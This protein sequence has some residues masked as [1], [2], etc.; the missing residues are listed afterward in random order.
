MNNLTNSQSAPRDLNS[1]AKKYAQ[2]IYG[3]VHPQDITILMGLNEAGANPTWQL[4]PDNLEQVQKA[5]W[6]AYKEAISDP[7]L[8]YNQR[9]WIHNTYIELGLS[10]NRKLAP[11]TQLNPTDTRDQFLHQVRKEVAHLIG[12]KHHASDNPSLPNNA[13]NPKP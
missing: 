11:S 7:T 6:I 3:Y 10:L 2:Y 4:T 9:E 12:S 8:P 13:K 5:A 1:D